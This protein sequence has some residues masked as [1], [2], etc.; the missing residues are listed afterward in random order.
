MKC[1][2]SSRR[3][4]RNH[5]FF[6][7]QGL[8][9]SWQRCR[10]WPPQTYGVCKTFS[11]GFSKYPSRVLTSN[12]DGGKESGE[13]ESTVQT[14]SGYDQRKKGVSSSLSLTSSSGSFGF[15][16]CHTGWTTVTEITSSSPLSDLTRSV[17]CAHGHA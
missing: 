8:T 4:S 9:V 10:E 7:A 17:R 16:F 3:T 6:S 2:Q 14:K 13:S 12:A 15:V 1:E 5:S 11:A